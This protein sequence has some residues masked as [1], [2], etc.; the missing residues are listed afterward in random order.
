MFYLFGFE[1]LETINFQKF[2]P[3]D[4]KYLDEIQV[5]L[6]C[7]L[8]SF[9]ILLLSVVLESVITSLFIEVNIKLKTLFFPK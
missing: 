8:V 1:A 5:S 3:K 2:N 4:I 7:V 9:F 6:F